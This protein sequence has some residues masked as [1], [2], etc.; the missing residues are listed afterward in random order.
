MEAVRTSETPVYSETTL[1]YIPEGSHLHTRRR[2]NL[3]SQ[4]IEIIFKNS[5]RT[6]N[7]T[8]SVT[9]T[10]INW[11]TLI[12]ETVAVYCENYTKLKNY[13]LWTKC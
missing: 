5:V 2:E 3:K 12:E 9:I 11:L 4:L 6:S 7:R 13:K 1:R 8:Q 10:R